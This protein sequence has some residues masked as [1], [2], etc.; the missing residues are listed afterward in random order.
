MGMCMLADGVKHVTQRERAAHQA[1]GTVEYGQDVDVRVDTPRGM[2]SLPPF[3]RVFV[4][5]M[6]NTVASDALIKA[7]KRGCSFRKGW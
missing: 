4:P 1:V 3:W 7:K 5:W 6:P 2:A